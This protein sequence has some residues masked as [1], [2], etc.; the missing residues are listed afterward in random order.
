M[1]TIFD[2]TIR[3][4]LLARIKLVNETCTASWGQMS[5]HQMLKH[6]IRWEK[7]ALGKKKYRLSIPGRLFG[8]M[9]LKGFI[10][11][12]TPFRRNVPTLP[13]LRIKDDGGDVESLKSEW[14]ALI[15]EYEHY[16]NFDF[17]HP[18]FGRMNKDQVGV[19]AYKHT[20]H[21]LRQFGC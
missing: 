10:K 14:I 7:M 21:H 8:K 1:K 13:D 11:D 4:Q 15:R 12:D 2:E 20:D 17:V 3:G 5:V 18:F 16:S 9:V 6:C 19:M